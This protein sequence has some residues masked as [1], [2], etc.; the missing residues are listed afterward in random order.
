MNKLIN[1]NNYLKELKKRAKTSRVYYKYQ[2]QGLEIS[3]IL[4]DKKH[5]SLYIKL[6]KEIDG[7]KLLQIAKTIT[8][9]KRIKNKG[10]YFMWKLKNEG[11]FKKLTKK[12]K[13]KKRK[14]S[15]RKQK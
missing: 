11:L 6:A 9:N 3:E 14:K 4:Q 8:E 1:V 5:K 10:A 12:Q 15:K 13:E 7:E 2:L